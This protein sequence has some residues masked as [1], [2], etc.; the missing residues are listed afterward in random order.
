M[1]Q[2]PLDF[3]D[4][5]SG[6]APPPSKWYAVGARQYECSAYPGVRVGH[7]GHLTCLRPWYVQGITLR[8]AFQK[9]ADAQTA[10]A[11]FYTRKTT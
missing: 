5:G 9:L 7:T 11:D 10:V 4:T 2:T 3:G 6:G 8:R 1:T